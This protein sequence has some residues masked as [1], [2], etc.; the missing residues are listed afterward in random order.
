MKITIT[1]TKKTPVHVTFTVFVNGA[2]SGE[3]VLR[4]EEW[5]QFMEILQPDTIRDESQR[6]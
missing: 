3:L 6:L 2:R 4:L 5:E 1:I